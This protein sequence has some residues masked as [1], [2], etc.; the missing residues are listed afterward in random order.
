MRLVP[1]V[2][3]NLVTQTADI[4]R[5]ALISREWERFLP[6]EH[7]LCSYLHISRPTLRNAIQRLEA[8]G[9]LKTT[10]GKRRMITLEALPETKPVLPSKIAMLSCQPLD[11][12]SHYFVVLYNE[13]FRR[14]RDYDCEIEFFSDRRLMKN[15][16]EVFLQQL[17]KDVACQL[18]ILSSPTESV[19]RWFSDHKIPAFVLGHRYDQINIPSLDMDLAATAQHAALTLLA[20][21]HRRIAFIRPGKNNAGDAI[22]EKTFVSHL[23]K[24]RGS[25]CELRVL[26]DGNSPPDHDRTIER[27]LGQP[28]RPTAVFICHAEA[29]IAFASRLLH[30]GVKIPQDVSIVSRDSSQSLDHFFP[31]IARYGKNVTAETGK[32][33][34]LLI[35][36]ISRGF[37]NSRQTL[38]IPEFHKGFS[39][40]SANK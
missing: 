30:H 2:R 13:I 20:K 37:I 31:D 1:P 23:E 28:H 34:S 9:L 14:M 40:A 6:G 16:S 7:R 4:I 18:W 26:V 11:M 10:H 29:T 38:I 33:T 25:D 39:I 8:E 5:K 17:V 12:C 36:F 15:R 19:Q 32:L 27:F 21:G 22:T 24:E 35:Q 3:S